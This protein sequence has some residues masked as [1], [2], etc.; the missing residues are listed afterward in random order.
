MGWGCEVDTLQCG[1]STSSGWLPQVW[2]TSLC[3][4]TTLLTL[5]RTI[6][7]CLRVWP[8]RRNCRIQITSLFF[9]FILSPHA[10]DI[11]KKEGIHYFSKE[12]RKLKNWLFYAWEKRHK[13]WQICFTHCNHD[14]MIIILLLLLAFYHRLCWSDKQWMYTSRFKTNKHKKLQ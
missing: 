6:L 5:L 10:P 2:R 13:S 14:M 8:W 7:Q 1:L 11:D 3:D 9:L 12:S 4:R